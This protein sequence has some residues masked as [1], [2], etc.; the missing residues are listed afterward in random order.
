MQGHPGAGRPVP[1]GRDVGVADR[2]VRREAQDLGLGGV[3]R[4][5][6]AGPPVRVRVHPGQLRL[7]GE[8]RLAH[9]GDHQEP[10]ER[11]LDQAQPRD[12]PDLAQ[13]DPR[14]EPRALGAGEE[15]AQV[16]LQVHR[17]RGRPHVHLALA[18]MTGPYRPGV[19][20]RAVD[21]DPAEADGLDRQADRRLL[22]VLPHEAEG[23]VPIA[24]RQLVRAHARQDAPD[25]VGGAARGFHAD[26]P[27]LEVLEVGG[28]HGPHLAE[29]VNTRPASRRTR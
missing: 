20:E 9:L 11:T 7:L 8:Q 22:S 28:V 19:T 1:Q 18:G 5:L 24:A 10:V 15:K 29:Q 21:A 12:S 26:R 17:A 6:T 25:P 13:D 16:A 23:P 4:V 2:A 3:E 27:V 14:R